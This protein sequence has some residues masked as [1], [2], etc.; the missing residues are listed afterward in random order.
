MLTN[1][2]VHIVKIGGEV[3]DYPHLLDQLIDFLSQQ[4]DPFVLVHGGGK[5]AT[6][7]AQRMGI[8][9]KM[10][11]GRRVT[12]Q[13]TLELA[14]MVYAGLLNKQLVAR[15]QA[16]HIDA[17]GLTGADGNLIRSSKRPSEPIDYGFAGD[18]EQVNTHQIMR[19]ISTG[20]VPVLA[21]ITHDRKGQLL[22]T[23]AD[24]IA[25][26]VAT[27]LAK[28]VSVSLHLCMNKIGVLDDAGAD[29][30]LISTLNFTQ[31]QELKKLGK[32]HS[33]MIPKLDNAFVAIDGGVK[34]VRLSS[35]ENLDFNGHTKLKGTQII[36]QTDSKYE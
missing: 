24:S 4:Q 22:N 28:K 20:S 15:L 8:E 34:S 32:I 14:C 7:M 35:P 23:N 1:A 3:L 27:A 10:I 9:S 33:G 16:H 26:A 5:Q 12:D 2:H 31:Y 21:A 36:K 11:A 18:I 30:T 6:E 25:T 13:A 19:L 17:W 29:D